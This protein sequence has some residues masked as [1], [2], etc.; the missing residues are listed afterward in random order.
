MKQLLLLLALAATTGVGASAQLKRAPYKLSVAVDK[1]TVYEEDIKETPY[2]LP[3]NTVQLYPGETVF[4]E[5][6]LAD[7]SITGMTAVK[8]NEHPEKTLVISFTQVASDKKHES[9]MLKVV[10]PFKQQL[11]YGAMIFLMKQ[12]KWVKTDVYPVE[13]GLAGFETW[14]DIITSIGLGQWKFK[15]K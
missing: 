5:V 14:P 10:N 8:E 2:V 11:S 1:G 13:A 4:I 7:N 3:N 6:E 9:M 15:A 12:K